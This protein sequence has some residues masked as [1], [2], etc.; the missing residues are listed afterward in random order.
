[1]W[2]FKIKL[3]EGTIKT[4]SEIN[5]KKTGHLDTLLLATKFRYETGH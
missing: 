1:M 5:P 3:F 4:K 2:I